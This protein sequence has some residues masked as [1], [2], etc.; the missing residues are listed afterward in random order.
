MIGGGVQQIKAVKSVQRL[1]YKILVTDRNPCSPCREYADYFL[2]FDGNDSTGI[3]QYILNNSKDINICGVFTLTELVVTAA[4]VA[5]NLGLPGVSVNSAIVCQ[6]KSMS[7]K[8]WLK[9]NIPTPKGGVF[10]NLSKA[11]EFFREYNEVF[12][13]PI[14]GFGGIGAGKIKSS[15]GLKDFFSE[16]NIGK[17]IVEEI[18][19][20]PMIDVNGYFDKNGSFNGLGCFEREFI[21]DKI[22]ESHAY[23]PCQRD[24][25]IIREAYHLTELACRALNIS[26]GPVKSDLVLTKSGLKV[27]EVAPRLHGPKGTLY[28]AGMVHDKNHL[29]FILPLIVGK[30]LKTNENK[31]IKKIAA[32]QI[33]DHPG[34]AFKQITGLNIIK[35]LG[36]KLLLFKD[37]LDAVPNNLDSSNVIGYVFAAANSEQELI[38]KLD[39]INRF[40]DYKHG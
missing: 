11:E 12:V 34:S 3:T 30:T 24:D 10:N 22:I 2:N 17:Y 28:L 29:E 19:D 33:I 4:E 37:S 16:N 23:Y 35:D 18:C 36:Y 32:F 5:S 26:W 8:F 14:E 1:G 40:I 39:K 20:G 6:N 38:K 25:E 21:T 7:K 31:M 15:K 13:K 9:E 27:F